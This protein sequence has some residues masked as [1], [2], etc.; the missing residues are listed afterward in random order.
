MHIFDY[1]VVVIGAGLAGERVAIA[2]HSEDASVAL[3]SLV[4]PRQSHS[5]AAEGGI[6]CSLD[7]MGEH[8]A[9][10]GWKLHFDDTVRGSDWGADQDVVERSIQ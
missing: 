6:Q 7:N 10:D 8:S 1:D 9:G 5:N 4:Q 3:I 2:A